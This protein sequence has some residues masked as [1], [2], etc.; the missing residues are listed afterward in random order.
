MTEFVLRH[1]FL[2]SSLSGHSRPE[3]WRSCSVKEE[4][5]SCFQDPRLG[6]KDG[7]LAAWPSVL[8]GVAWLVSSPLVSL[9]LGLCQLNGD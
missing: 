4:E 6:N 5:E 9:L 3:D 1:D 2:C 7:G 8:V